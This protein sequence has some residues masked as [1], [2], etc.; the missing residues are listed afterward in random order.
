MVALLFL[1][2]ELTDDIS[3]PGRV[4]PAQEWVVVRDASG[5]V[6]ATLR[7]YGSG[8]VEATYAAE[9]A[10]GDAVRFRLA[11]TVGTGSVEAG[12]TVGVFVSGE[13][14][15]RLAALEG[16]VASA[17]AEIRLSRAGEKD[18]LVEAARQEVLR[19][20]E[21][22]EQARRV[23]ARRCDLAER[24]VIAVDACEAATSARHLAE[25]EAAAA[26]ARLEAVQTGARDEEVALAQT[27]LV[28]LEPSS[29]SLT[30][31]L[32]PS[33]SP[34]GGRIVRA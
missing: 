25:A 31:R 29:W 30:R 12:D 34:S 23:G 4:F 6:S 28:A 32:T 10:R 5:A 16:Q 24:G 13:A 21:A 18:P 26:A 9:P 11:P 17:Q 3:V 8:A 20:R 27:R 1:P 14:A 2:V 22:L 7:D 33:P 19:A 15:L